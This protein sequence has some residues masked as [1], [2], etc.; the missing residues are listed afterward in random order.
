VTGSIP[1]ADGFLEY[2]IPDGSLWWEASPADVPGAAD[3]TAEV[4]RAIRNPYGSPSLRGIV[5]NPH[6][7]TVAVA[8]DDATRVTPVEKMLTPLLSELGDLGIPPSRV[9]VLFAV[10]SHRPMTEAEMREKIGDGNFELVHTKN[11]S[12]KKAGDLAELGATGGGTRVA[13]N[14]FFCESDIRIC[15]GNIIPQFIAGWSGGAKIIQ[16]GLS[17][18]DTTAQ[19]HL[20][21]S[22][23]WP[24][25]LGNAENSIRRDM[26]EIAR[27][28]GVHFIINSV[29]NARG[30]LV[31][32]VAGDVV[33]AHR[34]GVR[35]AE[36]IYVVPIPGKADIVI[37]G[38]H[39]ADRDL[40]QADKGLA[41]AV[42]A[43]RPG[44]TVIWAAPCLAGVSPEHPILLE[45]GDRQPEDVMRLCREGKLSD[46]LGA[47]A[48]IMIG[49]MRRM[50]HVILVSGGVKREEARRMGFGFADSLEEAVRAALE[51]EVPGARFGVLTCAA[52]LVPVSAQ[53][54][55]RRNA[56]S[57]L[58]IS[59]CV[60]S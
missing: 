34:E 20:R 4:L 59:S 25:R 30:G 45:L 33:A 55:E 54:S 51:R 46:P 9:T 21:G 41:A 5:G 22:L 49:V 26:E 35:E 37:A 36:K 27:M 15:I 23:D 12:F 32:V 31:R 1:Y 44:G 10:G 17:G 52:D 48:H 58:S 14:R 2:T 57:S 8:V 39:P 38:V 56:S 43:V 13:V 19:V 28:A 11:H 40:W 7:K 29:L 18:E 53:A 42:T 16:P 47:S 60:L 6:G 24:G 50:A 3:E